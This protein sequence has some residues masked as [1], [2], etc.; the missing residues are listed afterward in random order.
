MIV[1][2][3]RAARVIGLFDT[4]A[5]QN[6]IISTMIAIICTINF[7]IPNLTPF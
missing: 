5:P 4:Y 6:A 3:K 7:E 1:M 2:I